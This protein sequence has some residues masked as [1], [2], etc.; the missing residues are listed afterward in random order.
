[1]RASIERKHSIRSCRIALTVQS[2]WI[3]RTRN[4]TECVGEADASGRNAMP[5][6]SRHVSPQIDESPKRLTG[7][8][9][10]IAVLVE[11]QN[12][13]RSRA[14]LWRNGYQSRGL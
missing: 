14:R 13:K 1:M 10:W 12:R 11:G 9:N 4:R 7:N 6:S 5:R 8:W 2:V 3:A